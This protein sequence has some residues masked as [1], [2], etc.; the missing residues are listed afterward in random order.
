MNHIM[1]QNT[2]QNL[3]NIK[4]DHSKFTINMI[5]LVVTISLVHTVSRLYMLREI[6]HKNFRG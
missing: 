4:Y 1:I 5:V 2:I 6:I 3:H